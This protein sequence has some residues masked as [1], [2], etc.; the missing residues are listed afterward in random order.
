MSNLFWN[1]EGI[2]CEVIFFGLI[3]VFIGLRFKIWKVMRILFLGW[4]RKIL[5][6]KNNIKSLMLNISNFIE[7]VDNFDRKMVDLFI[8]IV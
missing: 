7:Y 6:C 3:V 1:L 8:F 5:Y 2:K 4:L